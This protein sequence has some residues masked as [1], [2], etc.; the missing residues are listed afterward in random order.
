MG[1]PSQPTSEPLA[2]CGG[3]GDGGGVGRSAGQLAPSRISLSLLS[4]T[5]SPS[6]PLRDST[7]IDMDIGPRNGDERECR[8]I[9][10][11]AIDT[12]SA[13]QDTKHAGAEISTPTQT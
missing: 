12:G 13:R 6:L 3:G 9:T 11:E 10:G 1:L 5:L 7:N 2:E 8:H 4:D